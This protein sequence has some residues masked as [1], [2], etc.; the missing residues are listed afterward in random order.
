MKI[1]KDD[2]PALIGTIIIHLILLL[3]LYFN[4]LR[5]I[6]P[7]EESGIL[8]DFGNISASIGSDEP[9]VAAS[10][11]QKEVPPPQ[12]KVKTPADEDVISQ[13][14][15]E[16]VA[17]PNKKKKETVDNT[18]REKERQEEIERKRAEDERLRR[19][20]QQ[21][22]QQENIENLANKAFGSGSSESSSQGDAT[23][24]AGNQGAP[25]GNS[26]TG[27]VQG[28]GGYGSFNLNGRSVG[29]GGLPRPSYSGM[30]EGRIVINITVDPNGNVLSAEIGR[31]TNIDTPSMRKSAIEAARRAKFNKIQGANNQSGTIT[32]N[33]KFTQ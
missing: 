17:I 24:E 13:D 2:I 28:I 7:E 21:R 20:Q 3:I 5:T 29:S 4:I 22:Q 19:E 15:E 18:A 8:V 1:K 9:R 30:E 31:G 14:Q 27:A 32:Y 33:Y 16:T 11:P 25:T 26:N 10:V 23:A 12:P 6:V